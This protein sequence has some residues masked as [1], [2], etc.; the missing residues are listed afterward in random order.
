ML[1]KVYLFWVK[2]EPF[3]VQKKGREVLVEVL[4]ASDS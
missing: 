4:Q 2:P 1:Q 3:G